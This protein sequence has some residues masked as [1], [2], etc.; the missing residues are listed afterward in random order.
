MKGSIIKMVPR[1]MKLKSYGL[2]VTYL[3]QNARS[4]PYCPIY[5]KDITLNGNSYT[6][7]ILPGRR[8]FINVLYTLRTSRESNSGEIK[9]EMITDN[10]VLSALLEI[11]IYLSK[12]IPLPQ[13]AEAAA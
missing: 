13:S 11:L 5:E 12:D 10:V 9:Y 2:F 3:S 1:K 4:K 8:N 6:L 7:F